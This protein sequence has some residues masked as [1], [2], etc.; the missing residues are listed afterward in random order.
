MEQLKNANLEDKTTN[1][2]L[3]FNQLPD[4]H[5]PK[6]Y[7]WP[8]NDN[9]IVTEVLDAPIIDLQG[10]FTHD[11]QAIANAANL[12]KESCMS[13]GLFQVVNHGIDLEL[14]ALV[15]KHGRAFFNLPIAE[16]MKCKKKEGIM[17]GFT[18]AHAHRFS[19]KLYWKEMLSFVYHENG[20]EEV[21]V[22]FFNSTLGDQYKETGLIYQKCCQSMRKLALDL[23]EL[24]AISLG[25][26][27]QNYFK[28]LYEDCVSL[29]RYN[30]YPKCNQPNLTQGV[31]PH[32][33]PNTITILF[34]DQVGGL[35]VVTDNKWKSVTPIPDALVVNIGDT[36]KALSNG[37]Y[38][39]SCL[40]RVAVNRFEPRLSVA[41]FLS[42]KG[43]KEVKPPQDLVN[44]DGKQEYP[45]FKWEQFLYFTLTKQRIDENTFEEFTKWLTYSKNPRYIS[46]W[47]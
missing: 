39:L 4:D 10:F 35:E 44:K 3:I 16:K 1:S 23:M 36:F 5:F 28:K 13:H 46:V 22:D 21:V 37:K 32:R 26:D 41:F 42:P 38:Y 7:I 15:D 2:S 18:N 9:D 24:L 14:L 34:Q 47:K 11:E 27:G 19:E 6:Q 31:G 17:L 45:D 8:K 40:H 20:P 30:Y 29:E 25:V 43:D 33:D 12:V